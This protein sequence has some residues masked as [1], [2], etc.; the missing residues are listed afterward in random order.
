MLIQCFSQYG[1]IYHSTFIGRAGNK[2]KGRISRFLANKCSIACRI[3]CFSDT[4]TTKYGE[5][6]R[7]QVEERLSFYESGTAVSKN[8][9]AIKK[10]Q[11]AIAAEDLE[12]EDD[13]GDE[14]DDAK[15]EEVAEAVRLV[16]AGKKAA[17]K[18]S[19]EQVTDPELAKIAAA[20]GVIAGV[21]PSKKSKKDKSSKRKADAMEV[22]TP[23]A[24]L[25]PVGVEAASPKKTKKEKAETDE[26][27]A[28][29]KAA[30]KA[31]KAAGETS[32]MEVDEPAAASPSKKDKKE[33]KS[34]RKSEGKSA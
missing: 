23:S 30:K 32:T 8:S 13:D 16:E 26:E 24:K 22:D 11:A 27:R 2:Y 33:K 21:T 10:A 6:L 1:L 34:K 25:E 15:E 17:L 7:A 28:A 29:R 4:P 5:A 31:A 3:D 19:G 12:G 20:S 18:E 14:D 9:D